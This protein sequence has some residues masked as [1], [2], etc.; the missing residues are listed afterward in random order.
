MIG[1]TMFV[2]GMA[3][4]A[5]A[6]IAGQL[7]QKLDPRY[8]LMAGFVFFAVGTWQMTE[9]HPGLGLLGIALAADFPRCRP[10]A[11]DRAGDQYRARHARA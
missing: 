1:D 11:G 5:T 9:R 6:P 8:V 10:D 3:M 2:S 4:F 7:S